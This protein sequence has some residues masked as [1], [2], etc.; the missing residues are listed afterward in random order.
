MPRTPKGCANIGGELARHL[1]HCRNEC[2]QLFSAYGYR[3]FSPAEFQLLDEVWAHL[4]G[5]RTERLLSVNSPFGEACALRT[6]ITFS[7]VSYLFS[8]H[9]RE[10][11]PLRLCYA[12]RIFGTPKFPKENLE[13]N[14]IGIELLGWEREGADAE[15]LSLL[16][17][18]LDRLGIERSLIVLGDASV[19]SGLLSPLAPALSKQ[20]ISALHEGSFV[21]YEQVLAEAHLAEADRRILTE[22]PRLKGTPG[23]LARAQEI[24]GDRISLGALKGVCRCMEELGYADRI[25]IDLGFT[26]DLE[27]YSGPIFRAYASPSGPALG[28]GGRYDQLLTSLGLPGQAVGFGLNLLELARACRTTPREPLA[29]IW[30]GSG[31]CNAPL[32]YAEKLREKDV[33][34]ELSWQMDPAASRELAIRRGYAWWIDYPGAQAHDLKGGRTTDLDNFCGEAAPC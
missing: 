21:K 13:E 33:A 9:T 8:H 14:Q 27:Y 24:L 22:L 23:V 28:S 20:L 19:I 10:E 34:F 18:A 7:A 3:P 15:V 12:D 25:R 2:L 1:E 11:F 16:L 31:P 6:D 30:C 17:R 5:P 26:L 29:M 32:E 4:R